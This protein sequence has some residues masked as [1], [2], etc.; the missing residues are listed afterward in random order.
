MIQRMR[1]GDKIALAAN[2]SALG[3]VHYGSMCSGTDVRCEAMQAFYQAAG[4]G[5][6]GEEGDH[7]KDFQA[8]R[9][10]ITRRWRTRGRRRAKGGAPTIQLGD[11]AFGLKS[12][13]GFW[14]RSAVAP[15]PPPSPN[16]IPTI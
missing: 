3:V 15:P 8:E 7:C 16:S 13:G 5:G 10:R 2:L 6:G 9:T 14:A 1:Q 11:A 12:F 4:G